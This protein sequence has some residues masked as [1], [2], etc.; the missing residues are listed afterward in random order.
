MINLGSRALFPHSKI[1]LFV[2][3]AS[4]HL[5]LRVTGHENESIWLRSPV[6]R[7]MFLNEM[8]EAA[9]KKVDIQVCLLLH[10]KG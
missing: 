3:S 4:R 6:F 9:S 5:F 2:L 1:C 8:T 7:A 10:R